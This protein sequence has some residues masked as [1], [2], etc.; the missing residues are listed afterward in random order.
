MLHSRHGLARPF[1]QPPER[2]HGSALRRP[3]HPTSP[4]TS[5]PPLASTRTTA[6]T[7]QPDGFWWTAG[8]DGLGEEPQADRARRE[9]AATAAAAAGERVMPGRKGDGR[10]RWTDATD[11][12]GWTRARVDQD[13]WMA[14]RVD[15]WMGL[16]PGD[17]KKGGGPRRDA[18]SRQRTGL[19]E[20]EGWG[21]R[22][23][24]RRGPWG[25]GTAS[26]PPGRKGGCRGERRERRAAGGERGG[27]RKAPLHVGPGLG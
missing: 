16:R 10:M 8:R 20:G 1:L 7:T 26:A 15:K 19:A 11:E 9:T 17:P 14:G 4:R 2:R 24:R 22:T 6:V 27:G 18:P 23:G 25:R 5:G 12:H 13:G 21:G 3:P